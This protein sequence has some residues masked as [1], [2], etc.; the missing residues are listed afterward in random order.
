MMNFTRMSHLLGEKTTGVSD[1]GLFRSELVKNGHCFTNHK[2]KKKRFNNC[3][4]IV[5]LTCHLL[6][7]DPL[8]HTSIVIYSVC[9][10]NVQPI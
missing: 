5:P 7:V 10:S 2:K 8:H 9:F 3:V 1:H 4:W 6:W